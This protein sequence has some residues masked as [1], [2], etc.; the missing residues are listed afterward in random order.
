MTDSNPLRPKIKKLVK[1]KIYRNTTKPP[2]LNRLTD[3]L[4]SAHG[5]PV[6]LFVKSPLGIIRI[7]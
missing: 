7:H 1:I 2:T 6:V 5:T 4:R 3:H